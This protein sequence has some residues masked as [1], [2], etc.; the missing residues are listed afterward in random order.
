MESFK[1]KSSF[2]RAL[3]G[4]L[5]LFCLVPLAHA[6]SRVKDL[7]PR[8]RHWLT[9]EVNYIIDSE[10]RKQFLSLTSDAQ[11]DAF[12][13][14]FWEIRNPD[15]G[16]ATNSYKEEFYQRLAYANEHFGSAQLQNGWRTARGRIY[17]ILGA[18]K[19]IMSYPAAR[20]VRPI[21]IWFYQ[22]PS[23]ALPP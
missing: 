4:L 21:E 11:R 12:I 5:I 17:I 20:N 9:E 15:P 1:L 3:G 14:Q 18:P 13:R 6:A 7:P 23:L 10:E 16:S 2:S 8:Y 22:S 19:Q